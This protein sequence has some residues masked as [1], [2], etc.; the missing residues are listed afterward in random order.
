MS[1]SRSNNPF[2]QRFAPAFAN[3]WR[4]WLYALMAVLLLSSLIELAHDHNAHKAREAADCAICQHSVSFDKTLPSEVPILLA[5]FGF[6]L[7]VSASYQQPSAPHR[8]AFRS[9]APPVFS[10]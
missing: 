7:G 3:H 6:C 5:A 8:L 10:A 9:R 4:R 1:T 2:A